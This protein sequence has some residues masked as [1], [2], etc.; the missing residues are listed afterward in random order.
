[1]S[2]LNLFGSMIKLLYPPHSTAGDAA[3]LAALDR[4]TAASQELTRR[5][6]NVDR[7]LANIQEAA[8]GLFS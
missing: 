6:A 3:L 8:E 7:A 5:A 4:N 1:M 2:K